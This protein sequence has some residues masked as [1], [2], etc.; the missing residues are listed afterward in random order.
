MRYKVTFTLSLDFAVRLL[1]APVVRRCGWGPS[2]C[3]S[4]ESA[5]MLTDGSSDSHPST[6]I[7][8]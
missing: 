5:S 2:V 8:R 7:S 1:G 3:A 4:E 6:L